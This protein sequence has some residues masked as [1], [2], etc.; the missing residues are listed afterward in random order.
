MGNRE[1]MF[2]GRGKQ[3]H[4]MTRDG[5]VERNEATGEEKRIS[6]REQD[7]DLRESAP[8]ERSLLPDRAILHRGQSS[9]HSQPLPEGRQKESAI[10]QSYG[11]EE[12]ERDVSIENSSNAS[13]KTANRPETTDMDQPLPSVL[14]AQDKGKKQPETPHNHTE[15][16]PLDSHSQLP[17]AGTTS[18]NLGKKKQQ[19]GTMYHQKF[20]QG[21]AKPG[22]DDASSPS[23]N[24]LQFTEDEKVS[25]NID[26]KLNRAQKHAEKADAKLSKAKEKLPARHHLK[27]EKVFD[28]AAGKKKRRLFFEKESLSKGEHLKGPIPLRPAKSVANFSILY[29]HN[30]MSQVEHENVGVKAAHRGSWTAEG[31]ARSAY[32]FYKT[33]PYRTVAK[34]E[35]QAAKSNVRYA[36]RK[37]LQEH[38]QLKSSVLSRFMQKQKIKRQYAKAAREAKRAAGTVKKTASATAKV[39]KALAGVVQRHPVAVSAV[40]LVILVIF[41]F[42]SFFSSF[43]NVAGGSLTSILASSYTAEDE[44]ILAAD[45]YYMG[46]ENQ[47]KDEIS[48]IER[49]HPGYDEYRYDVVEVGH[50]PFELISYLSVLYEDFALD[51]VKT[52]MD[53]LFERQYN[54]TLTEIVEVRYRTETRTDKWTDEEGNTHTDTYTVEVPYDYYILQVSLTSRPLSVIANEDMD[55]DQAELYS[56]RMETRGNKEY[57]FADR[58]FVHPSEDYIDYTIPPEALSDGKFA[59]MIQEAEKYLGFPYVWGGSTPATSF[60]C[61]GFVSWVVNQSGVASVGRTTAQG[62][63][64]QSTPVRPGEA[65]PGD[66]IFFTGTYDSAGAVSHVGIYVGNGMMIHCGNPIQY[67]S[68]STSYW[69]KHFYAYGRLN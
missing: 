11:G 19:H 43:S 47:L 50:N 26:R 46:L 5:L 28:E 16:A 64:N 22:G 53:S 41:C 38:P 15:N 39:V 21:A 32:R 29:A 56:L 68:V 60:D 14:K 17:L 55:D 67:A 1:Q 18:S 61:S 25:E 3:T 69:T 57:L 33:T 65:K 36:Y 9:R 27:T 48:R 12:F 62:L 13:P 6:Q 7:F 44:N 20:T 4:K 59:A 63:Y 52:T 10:Q 54:L 51:D 30:K 40:V 45:D 66:L 31:V 2:K 35:K 24:R 42:S 49:T 58:A 23:Q 34:L 37:L 8:Q